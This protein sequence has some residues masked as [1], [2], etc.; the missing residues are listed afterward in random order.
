MF[1]S[2][3]FKT[4]R[5][6][7]KKLLKGDGLVALT[8]NGSLQRN[9]DFAYPFRQDSSFFY[10]TGIEEPN[11]V[12]V[13][14]LLSD[15]E[16]LIL[17]MQSAVELYFGGATNRDKIANISGIKTMYMQKEGWAQFANLQ[18]NRKKIYSLLAPPVQFTRQ[19]RLFASPARRVFLQKVKRLSKLPI[20]SLQTQVVGL[21]MVKQPEEIAATRRAIEVTGMGLEA[22]RN[23]LKPG[24]YEYELEAEIDYAFKKQ[25]TGHA[26]GPPIVAGGVNTTVLHYQANDARLK[27]D[28][29]LLLDVGAEIHNYSADISR[30]YKV[31]GTLT[32][33]Q[34]AVYEAVLMVHQA[35][36]K[37]LKPGVLWRDYAVQVDELMGEQLIKL[38]LITHNSRSNVRPFFP[39]S[40]GHSL[41]LDTHDPFDYTQP[42]QENMLFAIEPGIYI[43]DE[44]IGV[45]IEDDILVTKNGALNLSADIPYV[46]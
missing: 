46:C 41:G 6:N 17:P 12:L 10:L 40:I 22:I 3:F 23:K 25:N 45:R 21:R 11:V 19:E 43:P 44:A 5:Q 39:H 15:E 38:Q 14:D 1:T 33:R 16:F 32:A 34:Q 30:T 27:K 35:S 28:D 2:D 29:L 31:A 24:V 42:I 8:A 4:N 36:I 20:E 37:L 26:F 18:A 7:L 9:N 13:M